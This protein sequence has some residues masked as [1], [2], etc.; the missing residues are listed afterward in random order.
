MKKFLIIDI[1]SV[2][3]RR[4]NITQKFTF[5]SDS[6]TVAPGFYAT[7]KVTAST[8]EYESPVG[9]STK[10][11]KKLDPQHNLATEKNQ[12]GITYDCSIVAYL[13][14]LFPSRVEK[15]SL[16]NYCFTCLTL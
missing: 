12:T 11:Y 4:S 15:L 1:C 8:Q 16:K 13:L 2:G 3:P 9:E 5:W 6:S 10:K 14:T 7:Y